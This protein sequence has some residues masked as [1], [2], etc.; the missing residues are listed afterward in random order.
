MRVMRPTSLPYP[1]VSETSAAAGPESPFCP[2][3]SVREWLPFSEWGGHIR[4]DFPDG[5]LVHPGALSSIRA[6]LEHRRPIAY[7]KGNSILVG[8]ALEDDSSRSMELTEAVAD[9]LLAIL[10][11]AEVGTTLVAH[12]VVG[13]ARTLEHTHEVPAPPLLR[14]VDSAGVDS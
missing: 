5:T 10:P 11:N 14:S 6:A 4:F 13:L 3:P 2:D 7:A 8:F 12:C 1:E 9:Y